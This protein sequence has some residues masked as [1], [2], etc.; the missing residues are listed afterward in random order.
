MSAI[1]PGRV[2]E[3]IEEVAYWRK[4]NAI[5]RWFVEHVQSDHDDCRE[6]CAPRETLQELLDIAQKVLTSCT[7]V[8]G[9]VTNGYALTRTKRGHV[10]EPILEDGLLIEDSTVAAELLPTQEGLFFGSTDYDE[11]YYRDLEY[12]R[13]VLTRALSTNDDGAYFYQSIW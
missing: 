13:D 5:H 11:G 4:A 8:P 7:L 6:H 10:E 1:K 2:T 3:I 12:T 9:K